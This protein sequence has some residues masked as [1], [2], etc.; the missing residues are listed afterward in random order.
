MRWP[1]AAT[2]RRAV[3]VWRW[4]AAL[5]AA[6]AV[7][8]AAI[9]LAYRAPLDLRYDVGG[10]P[11]PLFGTYGSERNSSF[12]YIYTSGKALLV[13]PQAGG[14]PQ[15][16]RLTLGGPALGTPVHAQL[17]AGG[18]TLDLGAVRERRVYHILTPVSDHGD[19][20]ADLLSETARLPG[21]RRPL[22]LLVDTIAVDSPR[23]VPPPP[24]A[25][26]TGVVAAL[27]LAALAGLLPLPLA[28]R[29]ALGGGAA[30]LALAGLWAAR[31][32]MELPPL[33]WQ[34]CTSAFVLG[35]ALL[36]R[37]GW[38]LRARCGAAVGAMFAVWRVGLWLAAAFALWFSS[39]LNRIGTALSRDGNSYG[40][41]GLLWNTLV[42]GWN[43]WDSEH[44]TTIAHT[45][46]VL[47]SRWPNVAFF[48]LYPLVIRPAALLL[49]GDYNLAAVL[50]ANLAFL[51]ALLLLYQL[52]AGDFGRRVAVFAVLFALLVPTS[53]FFGAAYSE[54]LALLLVVAA[55]W[56]IRRELW[57][58]AGIVGFL[59]ALTRIPGVAIA[60][61]LALAYLRSM[62]WRWRA[63]RW[64]MLAAALPPL[65]VAAFM[66]FQ[67]W[68]FG[69]P[70]A[71][72]QAQRAWENTLSPPWVLPLNLCVEPFHQQA[73][74]NVVFQGLFYV[75]FV[76]AAALALFRLPMAY[77]L[78]TALLLLPPLLSSW[79]W[80]V[81]R[82][83]LIGVA[84]Y[85]LLAQAAA[86]WRWARWV[87]P[88]LLVPLLLLAAM[89]FV[90]GWWVA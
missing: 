71:F 25:L 83:V 7:A 69:T 62:G 80:S 22:G 66:A 2:A 47:D 20:R 13:I 73:W 1:P 17:R 46:Y 59:L 65:G 50:V 10:E 37:S 51:A 88:L 14:G 28:A 26:L 38:V 86:R 33:W 45:G 60:P 34:A 30:A 21:D 79:V 35:C 55:I 41:D 77:G 9:W 15:I 82:H 57:W 11:A 27:T 40:R 53:F 84:V 76:G 18:D 74:P 36:V 58:L 63:V 72:M 4:A 29:A 16:A 19:I 8:L 78:S 24:F 61:L 75:G 6:C 87:A 23:D 39:A 43:Q 12:S 67:W 54:S 81:S 44:Y 49:G 56:A 90:N 85:V 89:L 3:P 5:A 31:G 48:P 32:R 42:Q 70:F 64:P 68:K 52:V